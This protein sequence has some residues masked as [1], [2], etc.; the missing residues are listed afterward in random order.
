MPLA[1]HKYTQF[2]KLIAI[3]GIYIHAYIHTHTHTHTHTHMRAR[4]IFRAAMK[5]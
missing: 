4:C 3:F 5:R 2:S 1:K